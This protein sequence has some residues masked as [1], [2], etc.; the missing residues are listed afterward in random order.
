MGFEKIKSLPDIG[1]IEKNLFKSDK[2][3]GLDD[4]LKKNFYDDRNT[5]FLKKGEKKNIDSIYFN[6]EIK[7]KVSLISFKKFDADL[8]IFALDESLKVRKESDFVFF[9]N[10]KPNKLGV[11]IEN[12]EGFLNLKNIPKDIKKIIVSFT[13]SQENFYFSDVKS[14]KLELIS[15]SN[16]KC[17]FSFETIEVYKNQKAL[18]LAEIYR[19]NEDW[20]ITAVGS[21]FNDGL[22]ALCDNYGVKAE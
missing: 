4:I 19:Y 11:F 17:F 21:G 6:D 15:N 1:K 7:L 3:I 20:K 16:K 2:L 9:N 10:P 13:I 12:N 18:I 8:F 22:I 14:V 5:Y